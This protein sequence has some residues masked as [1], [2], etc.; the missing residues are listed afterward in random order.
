MYLILRPWT[1]P[2]ALTSSNAMRMAL[3]LLTPCTAVTPDRSV[4]V[5]M[6]ISV[7]LTRR[8]WRRG[9]ADDRRRGE[10]AG[11]TSQH[12]TPCERRGVRHDRVSHTRS[13]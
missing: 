1:P 12:V 10:Q 7:S 2:L 3:A 11:G 13:G 4:M 8:A 5:P 9:A 6:M